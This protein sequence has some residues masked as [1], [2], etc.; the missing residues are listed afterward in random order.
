MM[1]KY[2][3]WLK[4]ECKRAVAALPVIM[5]KAVMLAIIAG[6]IAFCGQKIMGQS[7]EEAPIKIGYAAQDDRLTKLAVSFI[8]NMES[9]KSWCEL[10][11][12][13]EAEGREMLKNGTIAAF[14]VLPENMVEGIMTGSNEP[15]GLYIAETGS[16]YG[17][18]FEELAKAGVGM[19]KTA[20]AEIYAS[21]ML[22]TQFD[23]G[24]DELQEIYE[25]IDRFNLGIVMARENYFKNRTL[26][27]TGNEST[28]VYYGS[29][30]LTLYLVACGLF[31]GK[32]LRRS[33]ME[34]RMLVKRQSLSVE[35]MLAGRIF[36]AMGLFLPVLL[37]FG[38]L[39]A[40]PDFRGQIVL[41]FSMGSVCLLL[42][43][44][45]FLALWQQFLQLCTANRG[46]A[47][48][49]GA[50]SGI[51]FGYFA[52]CFVPSALLPQ[53][54]V[55]IASF[56]PVTY[57]R[58]CGVLV[59]S[60]TGDAAS[61]ILVLGIWS[62]VLFAFCSFLARIQMYRQT[63]ENEKQ[64]VSG[65]VFGTSTVVIM[66][67]RLL[68]K[69]SF[70][71]C[72]LLTV[73]VSAAT[74]R[75]EEK[76]DTIIYAV[77]HAQDEEW[78]QV[79]SEYDGLVR[80]LICDSEEEVKRYVIQKKAECGYVLQ[81]DLQRKIM[82]GNGNW[83]VTV[84]ESNGSMLTEMVNEVLFE[85]IFYVISSEWYA[86]YIAEQECFAQT[87]TEVGK[88]VFQEAAENALAE[89]MLDGSTFDFQ[90]FSVEN[91]EVSTEGT[92]KN[93][94]YP[95]WAVSGACILFCGVIGTLDAC[96]DKKKGRFPKKSGLRMAAITITL[97][98]AGGVLAGIL[99]LLFC[100]V[101]QTFWQTVI[102]FMMAL[103]AIGAGIG[104]QWLYGR[105]RT[106]RKI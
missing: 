12:V 66:T 58:E 19:L 38:F 39:F 92:E 17:L 99:T 96:A 102:L 57:I 63:K 4:T 62:L 14:L 3:V 42:L 34:Q 55:K 85:R 37:P 43:S 31:L 9:V 53:I 95:V 97:P 68:R 82:D 105:K 23:C 76:S 13:T 88:D 59:L 100:G 61:G 21:G 30:L 60:G 33:G 90:T 71:I 1:K 6:V 75:M 28:T 93:S 83:E 36:I 32:V 106:G 51:F 84:Y 67:K 20:Q 22:T 8:E 27:V 35:G 64:R 15:A 52:G 69:K 101:L 16:P 47:L 98:I 91:G 103:L 77:V 87:E 48:L 11:P 26:S 45:C 40:I 50:L 73:L 5:V 46:T 2:F 70:L 80:F 94:F 25:E 72:L 78:E 89:K 81:E 65:T 41:S 18:V 86:G 104:I 56:L 29:A 54:V 24:V 49:C 7:R 44:F 79:L 74:V 10:V